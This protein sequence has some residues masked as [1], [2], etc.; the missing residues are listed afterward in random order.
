MV[1]NN[2]YFCPT[3][4]TRKYEAFANDK[5]FL[6][7][8]N[9][10]YIPHLVSLIWKDDI[11]QM[12]EYVEVEGNQQYLEDFYLKGLELTGLA[13]EKGVNILAGTDSYDPYSFPGISLHSELEELV[14][15][16][17]S[18]AEALKSATI[19]PA[20]YF[21]VSEMLEPGKT[22]SVEFVADKQGT[23]SFFCNVFCGSGHGNMKGTLIVK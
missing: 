20:E 13:H 14:K 9:L 11:S 10:K 19:I 5:V 12:K 4:I 22:V 8:A 16:G 21:N 3:H 15:A 6:D 23:F 2:T 1:K 17:L 7:D 18:P